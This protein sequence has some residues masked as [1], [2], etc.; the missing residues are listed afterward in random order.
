MALTL[1]VVIKA[2]LLSKERGGDRRRLTRRGH[3]TPSV[4]TGWN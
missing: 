1:G 2:L 4:E 3:T